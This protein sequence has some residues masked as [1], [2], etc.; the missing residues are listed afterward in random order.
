MIQMG[1]SRSDIHDSLTKQRFN[2]I[3]ATYILL[4]QR[5]QKSLPWPP[6]LSGVVQPR[7]LPTET[8]I[9]NG[10]ASSTANGRQQ[11]PQTR[12]LASTTTSTAASFRRPF[13][14]SN[15]ATEATTIGRKFSNTESN[16]TPDGYRKSSIPGVLNIGILVHWT[17][18]TY[19]AVQYLI[20]VYLLAEGQCTATSN[21][22]TGSTEED[23]GFMN[24][25]LAT[26]DNDDVNSASPSFSTIMAGGKNIMGTLKK[27]K[28]GLEAPETSSSD[29]PVLSS[30]LHETTPGTSKLVKNQP[31][32]L[33]NSATSPTIVDSTVSGV[34]GWFLFL[35]S[36]L[37]A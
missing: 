5:K 15:S 13:N 18:F 19:S 7:S 27:Q 32:V 31:V 35:F 9:I 21:V 20:T 12:Q 36:V 30:L 3:T 17:I 24:A 10:S 25:P 6:T 14:T 28:T 26:T 2:N 22:K 4:G 29:S 37:F 16:Q 11:T 1:F 34:L 33:S 8:P 23:A